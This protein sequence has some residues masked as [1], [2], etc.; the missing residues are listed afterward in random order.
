MAVT[1]VTVE[2]GTNHYHFSLRGNFEACF[3]VLWRDTKK[4]KKPEHYVNYG[5]LS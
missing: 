1:V 4:K 3:A 5:I 2:F